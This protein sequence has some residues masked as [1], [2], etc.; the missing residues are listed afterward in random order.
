MKK[1]TLVLLSFGALSLSLPVMAD[2][3]SWT[4]TTSCNGNTYTA[5]G[6]NAQTLVQEECT[7]K[8]P[9]TGGLQN[10]CEQNLSCKVQ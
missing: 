5:K 1:I 2:S 3:N 9:G 6:I 7:N 8:C 10:Q 4:C